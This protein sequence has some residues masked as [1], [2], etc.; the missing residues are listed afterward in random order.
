MEGVAVPLT[1][2]AFIES[3]R[4]PRWRTFLLGCWIWLR[5]RFRHNPGFVTAAIT[6]SIGLVLTLLLLLNGGIGLNA[7]GKSEESDQDVTANLGTEG[8]LPPAEKT[9]DANLALDL[10][11][12]S[13]PP[14]RLPEEVFDVEDLSE[15]KVDRDNS[16]E[17]DNRLADARSSVPAR[18]VSSKPG[19]S[20]A[21]ARSTRPS[22]DEDD[23]SDSRDEP[24]SNELPA[25]SPGRASLRG[26]E[27]SREEEKVEEQEE[28]AEQKPDNDRDSLLDNLPLRLRNDAPADTEDAVPEE[29]KPV[30][31]SPPELAEDDPADKMETETEPFVVE[32]RKTQTRGT[33]VVKAVPPLQ[34]IEDEPSATED[35][36]YLQPKRS[37][38]WKDSKAR[39]LPPVREAPRESVAES[40]AQNREVEAAVFAEPRQREES[41]R[42]M[43][44]RDSADRPK[45]SLEIRAPKY[46]SPGQLFDLDF[47]VTN[48]SRQPVEGASL[49]VVLPAGLV[50]PQ[51]AELEQSILSIGGCEQYRGR[52]RVKAVGS[53][54]VTPRADVSVRGKMGVQMALTLRV[55][56]VRTVRSATLDACECEPLL[57]VR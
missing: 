10:R 43:P 22:F 49:S 14:G 23:P 39:P 41:S 52:L 16:D 42:P 50:H 54:E 15:K 9:D 32:Q 35:D 53:G 38:T 4:R 37:A 51:G 28:E 2:P 8:D 30:R 46:V 3:D 57:L 12:S 34:K 47:I 19:L 40:P 21:P 24:E 17:R 11:V 29:T 36:R 27:E 44:D 48:N 1:K 45:L 18:P 31:R 33:T 56:T 26:G 13:A 20:R 55:G 5:L 7:T 25:L 6:G